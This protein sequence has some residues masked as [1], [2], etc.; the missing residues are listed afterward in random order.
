MNKLLVLAL[1]AFCAM[2]IDAQTFQ[3]SRGW[4]NGKRSSGSV[5]ELP[6]YRQMMPS[7]VVQVLTA[8]DLNSRE[9]YT[10]RE[11]VPSTR[12]INFTFLLVVFSSRS[13]PD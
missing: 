8:N 13:P 12:I 5:T 7:P 2:E 11:H 6:P 1:I 4:T 3:Y 9:R 10:K